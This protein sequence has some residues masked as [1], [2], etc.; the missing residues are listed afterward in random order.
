MPGRVYRR[1]TR[2]RHA[3]CRCSTRSRGWSSTA[4][5]PSAIWPAPSTRSPRRTSATTSTSRL[6]P[7]YFPFTEPSAEFDIRRARRRRWLE[8]GG[9]GMVHPNVLRQRGHRPRGVVG[10]RL[11]VRHR[12]PGADAPRRRRPARALRPTTSASSSS[13][14]DRSRG[15]MKVLLSWLRD[16]AP[17]DGD[18]VALGE[19]AQRP[20]HRRR[21]AG[22]DRRGPRR[23]SSWPGCSPPAPHPER[24]QDP[25][26][27]RRRRRRRAA[28]DRAAARSTWP[29]ATSCRS[30]PSAPTMP[31]RHGDRP[32]QA[33]G[34]VVQRDAVLGP[35]ARPRRRPRRHPRSSPRD[36]PAGHAA[37]RGPRHRAPTSS[38]TS[39]STPT[40]PTP[41]R[42]PAS[43][44]TSPPGSACRSRCPSPSV[45]R[46]SGRPHRAGAR[47]RSSTPD[48]CGRFT[49]RVLARRRRSAPSPDVDATAAHPA[50]HA[51]DQQRRRRL[52]LRDARAGPAQPPLR[53]RPACRAAGCGSGGRSDGET[54]VTLDDVERT[55]TADDLPDL[56]RRGHARSA[57]PGSWAAPPPRS[58]SST[59]DV[60]LEMAW[61][62]PMAIARTSKRLG[63]RTE[64]SARFEQGTDPEVHRPGAAAGSPSCSAESG[65]P[66][67]GRHRRRAGRPARPAPG[68]GAHR[69]RQPP[70]RH[71]LSTPTEIARPARARSASPPTGGRAGDARRRPSRRG[72]PT[73]ATEIDVI[74]EVARHHGYARIAADACPP[75]PHAGRP[76]PR[77]SAS[78]ARLRGVARRRSGSPR[79]MPLPFLAPG[80]LERCG[81]PGDGIEHREPAGRPRSRCCARRCCPG[82]LAGARPTTPPAATRRARCSRSATCSCRRPS[83]QPLPDEREHARRWRSA[84]REAPGGG[85][86]PGSVAGRARSACRRRAVVNERGAR[87]APDPVGRGRWSAASAVGVVGEV[88][89]A[90]LDGPRHRRAGRRGS[91]ST[92]ARCSTLPHGDRAVPARS[93]ATRRATST[94]PSRCDDAVPAAAVEAA[95]A[96]AAGRPA[97]RPPAVRRLP[98][99]R[100]RATAAA[101]WPTACASTPPTARSPTPRWPRSASAASPRSRPRSRPRCGAEHA[102]PRRPERR[103]M[104]MHT[105]VCCAGDHGRHHR[106]V[107]VH[108]RRAAAP[109]AP[110]TPTST[111]GWPPAT[112]RPAR[113][114]PT[115]T[116]AWPPP[117]PTWSST[118]YDAAAG[119]RAR[120]RLPRPAPR[121]VAGARARARASGWATSSTW[122]PTSGCSDP[123]LY[124]RWYGEEHT[125]PEL[126][127]RLRLRPARAVPR[128]HRRRRR[129][130][131]PPGCYPTAAALALAPLR[132]GRAD[133]ADRH[134]RRRRQRRVGRRP[135]AEADHARSA[136]STRTSPPTACSTT[137]TRPRSSRPLGAPGAVHARTWRR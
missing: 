137:A 69:P 115:S 66:P 51:A 5:S 125:A 23:R 19:R 100:H 134:R 48:L 128:R 22:R 38:T 46:G 2:R 57:S 90:V 71:R 130:S 79:R 53:P 61:F 35:R 78:G 127:G 44:A 91:R 37:R 40:G 101:A 93:A 47:S 111:C 7:S 24:R 26:G 105:S 56:R 77:A 89:P 14:E 129:S 27:R 95:I 16:F 110:G 63:L 10:L 72:G 86:R 33:A 6:R 106:G 52:E 114:S 119:R 11:R 17:F 68:P 41:C 75:S 108:R 50:R 1:D 36:L 13:S 103:C 42:S 54:L 28:A 104:S 49:A 124:P 113:R 87:P 55:L 123:A 94:W 62:P 131:P 34:R 85:R 29:P 8:L 31:E 136:R 97:R 76:R 9:C 121:R 112:A 117:T 60:L 122:P 107:G 98:R 126:L 18:P 64:A 88:D 92:S 67:R 73:S 3:T 109:A 58:P 99:R 43:P 15:T 70:A 4:A 102:A 84:G 74:E 135:A 65:A 45:D 39:R 12:P 59:T 83:G 96:R 133:R 21:A 32:P 20:R 81:L 118:P 82:L 116:R 132:A 80:D 25:A 120:P 30:P